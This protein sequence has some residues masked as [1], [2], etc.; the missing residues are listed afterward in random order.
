MKFNLKSI[1]ICG[2]ALF[3]SIIL[4]FTATNN[5]KDAK[6]ADS[7][8]DRRTVIIGLDDTFVPMGFKDENGELTGFDVELAKLMLG[9]LG[10]EYKFQAINWDMKETE[11]KNGQIDL[12]WNGYTKTPERAEKVGLTNAYLNNTQAI[13]TLSD[14]NINKKVDLKDKIIA[15]QTASSSLDAIEKDTF[16]PTNIKNN[17]P[18]LFDTYNEAFMDLEA[19]RVDAIVVDEILARYYIAQRNSNKYKVLNDNLANEEYVIGTRKDDTILQE[20]NSELEKI[21][22]NGKFDEIKNKWF[23]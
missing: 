7:K 10:Y 21:K 1:I 23:K 6:D 2:L 16:L 15:T 13:V 22:A 8:T 3:A 5:N 20:L 11:L 9:N 17:T 12:I 4:I 14:S 18:I 19:R